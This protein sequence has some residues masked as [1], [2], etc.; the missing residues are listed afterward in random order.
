MRV[1]CSKEAGIWTV[2]LDGWYVTQFW[3]NGE[4]RAIRMA[5][6]LA[7]ILGAVLVVE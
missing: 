3:W 5:G 7:S 1:R 6:N 4:T 2:R